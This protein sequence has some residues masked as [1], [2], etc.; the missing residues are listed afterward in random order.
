M[1][2]PTEEFD[3]D[4]MHDTSTNTARITIN[5]AGIYLVQIRVATVTVITSTGAAIFGELQKNGSALDRLFNLPTT[6]NNSTTFIMTGSNFY[7][8]NASDY[9]ELSI[10]HN[11]G[12]AED[13]IGNLSAVW[14]GET[15]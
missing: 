10:Y 3:T 14:V 7:D 6:F 9:I 2:F 1:T 15:T 11:T 13:M 12:S 8:L 4:G 5:T